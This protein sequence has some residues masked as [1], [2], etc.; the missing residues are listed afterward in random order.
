MRKLLKNVVAFIFI[1][2]ISS[3]IGQQLSGGGS[4]SGG[5]GTPGGSNTQ[6]QYNNSSAFGGISG[7]TTNGTSLQITANGALSSGTGPGLAANGTWITGGS[8]TTTKP[9]ILI[10][11]TGTSSTIW[12]TTGTGLGINAPSGFTGNVVQFAVNN[13]SIT[14][15]DQF[16][17][18]NSNGIQSGGGNLV[19]ISTSLAN[20][21]GGVNILTA[22]VYGIASSG[23]AGNAADV[24]WGRNAP[25]TFRLGAANAASP[26]AQTLTSQGSRAATDTNIG[27]SSLTVQAG[28]GTGTGALSSLILQSPVAVGS[29]TGAQTQTTGLTI[30]NGTAITTGYTVS[31]LPATHVA[32]ARA[33]VT[34]ATACTFLGALTGGG[35][36]SC[37]VVDNGT[38]WVG[39]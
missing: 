23:G 24:M 17:N 11:P 9:Y 33:H 31:T 18:L 19:M 22:G 12:S 30:K 13:S 1:A 35:S 21:V 29:G 20:T 4:G 39:G 8:A 37:P 16:G 34:D 27:G 6:I 14:T 25:A 28:T 7:V 38:A 3:A 2:G 5:G 32:G 10:E 15:L 26:V 36:T